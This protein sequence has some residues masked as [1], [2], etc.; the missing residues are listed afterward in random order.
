[1]ESDVIRGLVD[2]G[3]V[4]IASGG[5][6]IPV[7]RR[8]DGLLQGVEAVIDK[9]LAG[10]RLAQQVNAQAFVIL[11][12][13]PNVCVHYGKP[14]EQKLGEITAGELR[15]LAA[16]GHFR[17]G[18][19][20]PKVEAALR[21]VENGGAFALIANLEQAVEALEGK[22]GPESSRGE[23]VRASGVS[24]IG[25][26]RGWRRMVRQGP[27]PVCA[28][29][30]CAVACIT[31]SLLRQVAQKGF[32]GVRWRISGFFGGSFVCGSG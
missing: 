11:T 8:D 21:F 29:G 31:C 1:V 16:E 28:S 10:E 12:D 27:S 9:D 6:G 14:Y 30:V 13:V 32:H 24:G 23:P 5:G 3:A 2:R 25:V 19:M 26:V 15:R 4:V 18:S 22:R 7:V 17:S 20:G